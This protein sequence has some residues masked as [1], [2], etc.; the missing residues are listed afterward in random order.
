MEQY[1]FNTDRY[2]FFEN[3]DDNVI[4]NLNPLKNFHLNKL[5]HLD[6]SVNKLKRSDAELLANSQFDELIYFTVSCIFFAY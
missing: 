5:V 6:V 2:I 3:S 4:T 1:Y